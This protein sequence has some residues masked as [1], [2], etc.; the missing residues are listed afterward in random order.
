[1]IFI[2]GYENDFYNSVLSIK[3]GWEKQNIK[4]NTRGV[5][6]NNSE[7]TEVVWMKKQFCNATKPR[8][9]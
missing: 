2:S 6:G 8:T 3:N 5:N 1:M 4:A 7:R 9:N